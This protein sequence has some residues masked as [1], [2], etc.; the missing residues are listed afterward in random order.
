MKREKCNFH[1]HSIYCD[2]KSPINEFVE[3]ASMRQYSQLGFSSHAPVPFAN[4]F[5]IKTDEIPSY[6]QEI[7]SQQQQHPELTLYAGLEC[8]YIPG[9]SQPFEMYKNKYQLDFI[10]GGVHLVKATNGELWFIDGSK[11]EI[12][13]NGLQT[14]FGGDIRK[15]VTAFWEQTFEMIEN[16]QFD[17][18]AHLD[19]IKM[20]NQKRFFTENEKWYLALVDH[21][22]ELIRRKNLIVEINTRGIYKKRCT[23]F[24]PSDYILARLARENVPMVVSTDAHQVNELSLGYEEAVEKLKSFQINHLVFLKDKKWVEYEI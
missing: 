21:S 24:Y 15:A 13:D 2:G 7:S 17:I 4:D 8:D 23:D 19:K 22:I 10:I 3:E 20:H 12:Y 14:L 5:G 11:R 18:I 16:E 1:T 6:H 9:M